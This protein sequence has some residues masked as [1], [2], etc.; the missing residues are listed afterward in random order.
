[1]A[2]SECSVLVV[3]DND[4]TL[5]ML[6]RMLERD[7]FRPIATGNSSEALDYLDAED[8]DVILVDLMLP[9]MTGL[10]FIRHVRRI[11]NHDLTPIVAISAFDQTYLAA[12]IMA[13]ADAALHKPE[14]VE[15]LT[16]TIKDVLF[17]I[18]WP[19]VICP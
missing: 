15:R 6:C 8:P 7:G 11:A 17:R 12:A 14:D 13:G 10:E 1:M 3:E 19:D 2:L 4:D 18:K 16:R 5:Q 9:E